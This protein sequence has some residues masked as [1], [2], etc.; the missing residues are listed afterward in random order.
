MSTEKVAAS[1]VKCRELSPHF[2]ENTD[3]G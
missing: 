3:H 2:L 1:V